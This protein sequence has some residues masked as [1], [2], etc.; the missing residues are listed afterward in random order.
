ML[1][2]ESNTDYFELLSQRLQALYCINF[3]DTGFTE[4]EWLARYGDL[5][6]D[7]AIVVYANKYD[8]TAFKK[9]S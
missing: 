9:L 6:L 8:L 1:K 3:E 2:K 5:E 7:E 4:S